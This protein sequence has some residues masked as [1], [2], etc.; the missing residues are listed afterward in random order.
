M[1]SASE[2]DAV[3]ER[4][5]LIERDVA[6]LRDVD[7]EMRLR[8]VLSSGSKVDQYVYWSVA[9]GRAKDT[10]ERQAREA[11]ASARANTASSVRSTPFD[12]VLAE[13]EDRLLGEERARRTDN[14]RQVVDAA[15]SVLDTCVMGIHEVKDSFGLYAKGRY[16]APPDPAATGPASGTIAREA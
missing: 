11:R 10:R 4:M 6:S 3:R 15:R 16:H 8:G 9:K 13:I 7:L 2:R 5:A 14:A 12:S 1:L